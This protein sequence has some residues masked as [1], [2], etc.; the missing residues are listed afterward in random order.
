MFKWPEYA[1][2]NDTADILLID[3]DRTYY[4]INNIFSTI[5]SCFRSKHVHIGLDEAYLVG[6]GRHMDLYGYEEKHV[7]LK[8]HIEM[9]MNIARKYDFSAEIW[10][11]MYFREAFGGGYYSATQGLSDEICEEIPKSVG[12]VYWDYWNRD[13]QV[14]ENMFKNHIKTKNEITFAGGAWKWSGWN[15][16]NR[17]ALVVGRKMLDACKRHK[18]GSVI[19]TAWSDDGAE[20]SIFT[21]LPSIVLYS[22]YAY[23]QKTD[24]QSISDIVKRQTGLTLEEYCVADLDFFAGSGREETYLFGTLPKILLYNDPLSGFYDGIL[25]NYQLT[26]KIKYCREELKRIS[27]LCTSEE[28]AAFDIMIS[29]CNVLEI[30]WDLGLRV[31]DAYQRDDRE[32][33]YQISDVDI[34]ELLNRLARFKPLFYRGWMAENK[35]N[36]FGTHDLRLGGVSDRIRTVRMLINSYLNNEIKSISEL[37]EKLLDFDE[38]STLDMLLWTTWKRIHT[39]YVM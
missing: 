3:D 34:P 38:N 18:I 2:C 14:I 16:S 35:T 19:L 28:K 24:D 26:E 1:G 29:L 33:L 8:R 4:L 9:V 23:S 6:R 21:T 17:M 12:L 36:G 25:K 32:A 22:A 15:P 30:K 5:S 37:D 31:R 27:G 11:D 10:S 20:A 39:I 7:L 13:E